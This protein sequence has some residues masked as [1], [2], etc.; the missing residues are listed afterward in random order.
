MGLWP[1]FALSAPKDTMGNRLGEEVLDGPFS[2]QPTRELPPNLRS[3]AK[4]STFF[5]GSLLVLPSVCLLPK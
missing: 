4:K 5:M 1:L 3:S 2:L